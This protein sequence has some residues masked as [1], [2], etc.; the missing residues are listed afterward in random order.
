MLS[1][2]SL[3]KQLCHWLLGGKD[4]KGRHLLTSHFCFLQEMKRNPAQ[5]I[6]NETLLLMA[7]MR[8]QVLVCSPELSHWRLGIEALTPCDIRRL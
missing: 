3:V 2:Q 7:A 8:G 1:C 5:V 4:G 6:H